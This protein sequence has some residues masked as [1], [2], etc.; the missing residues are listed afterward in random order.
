MDTLPPEL[1]I[2]ILEWAYYDAGALAQPMAEHINLRTLK[3]CS[4]VSP[5]WR[6]PSQQLL[7]RSV[8]FGHGDFGQAIESFY[9]ATDPST[10]RGRR[11]GSFV[12]TVDMLVG[13]LN[14]PHHTVRGFP[15]VLSRCSRLYEVVIRVSGIHEFDEETMSE[16]RCLANGRSAIHI[17]ALS[18]LLC[19]IQSPI[20]F[21]LLG[22]WPTVRFLRIGTELNATPP[23]RSSNLKLYE[24]ILHRNPSPEI[25]RWLLSNPE[26][27]LQI[28]EFRDVPGPKWD[29]LLAEHGARL[30]SLRLTR[31]SAHAQA[32]LRH[33]P[34]LEEAVFYQVSPFPQLVGL[35]S[36][37]EHLGFRN[38]VWSSSPSLRSI[39]SVIDTLPRLRIVT[40]DAATETHPDFALLQRKCEKRGIEL[41]TDALPVWTREDPVPVRHFPRR[42]SVSN[43][44]FMN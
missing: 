28:A 39:I 30:R 24:L 7:F 14:V 40:C 35:P 31:Y 23:A 32:V 29:D 19:G 18:I 34:N 17:Q 22:V 12:R 38:P 36:S 9:Y 4:L 43:F 41:C 15:M 11:L 10:G 25:A 3:A 27:D 2:S 1:I 20:L 42:K 37:L 33:C 6:E 5:S 13:H 26:T 44:A 16:L 8:Q 21:Q